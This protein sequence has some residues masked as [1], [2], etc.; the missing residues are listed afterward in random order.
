M[1]RI[2]FLSHMYP[3]TLDKDYGKVIHEQA[4]SLVRL[5]YEVKVICPVPHTFKMLKYVNK[6]YE[7]Y[8]SLPQKEIHE[9]IEVYYPR[10]W[11]LPK[12]ILLETEFKRLYKP[13]K[14]IVEQEL[15]E[16]S[17][18]LIHAHFGYPDGKA[19]E[20][21]AEDYQV[22]FNI[23][24]QST[25]LDKTI[26]KSQQMKKIIVENFQNANQVIVPSPRLKRK[27]ELQTSVT[28]SFIGYGIDL[29]S[30]RKENT[31][32]KQPK[33]V[34]SFNIVSIGRL[35]STKGF[36]YSILAM[37]EIVNKYPNVKLYVIG[38]GP[39]EEELKKLISEN[40]L[41]D[42]I[43]L[44]GGLEHSVAME[45]LSVADIFL[46]PSW[47]ETFGLV[48]AEAMANGVLTIGCEGQGFDGIIKDKENGLLVAPKSSQSI[49]DAIHFVLNNEAVAM[50]IAEK[51]KKT[52]ESTLTFEKIAEQ[53]G[54]IY[55]SLE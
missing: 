31:D 36:D 38:A 23:T 8:I 53:I 21:L 26:Y 30:V 37:K 25:D 6:K 1:E 17:F 14:K 24:L 27:L 32:L 34:D 28:A 9:G 29:D 47:Q 39:E 20:L 19:A 4:L 44:L 16:F 50:E 45:Y 55:Q 52:V 42:Y 43:E 13:V 22:P 18:D 46:L 40:G 48:Y 49:V 5:G 3:T 35:L 33:F 54:E 2:L 15:S 12:Q 41:N 7:K 51:G 10:Y 11:R